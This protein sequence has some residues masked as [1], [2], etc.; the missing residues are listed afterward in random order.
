MKQY[1]LKKDCPRIYKEAGDCYNNEFA[2]SIDELLAK[3]VIEEE[4]EEEFSN[5][6]ASTGSQSNLGLFSR[7][8]NLMENAI[9][10]Q[11]TQQFKNFIFGK[12]WL[13]SKDGMRPGSFKVIRDLP[14]DILVKA[15][16]T[17][18]IHINAK[19]DGKK[20]ADFSVSILLPVD[21]ANQMIAAQAQMKA[22]RST[23]AA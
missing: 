22:Q 21:V 2:E 12:I 8:N 18:P 9:Q 5:N 14:R 13:T 10:A 7:T 16:Q 6:P 15:G 11:S 3:G 1:I 4:T 20:D 23:T 19:R 17:Y